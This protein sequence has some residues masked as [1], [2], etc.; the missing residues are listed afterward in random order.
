MADM[1]C[2]RHD[3]KFLWVSFSVTGMKKRPRE[4]VVDCMEE[5]GSAMR[6][7]ELDRGKKIPYGI[8]GSVYH[9]K[10]WREQGTVVS[11]P[12]LRVNIVTGK[13]E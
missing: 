13:A 11:G 10:D 7:E 3:G 4:R 6:W 8:S 9:V 5:D 12:W 1:T 2:A